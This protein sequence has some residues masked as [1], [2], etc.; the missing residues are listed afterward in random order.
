MQKKFT[1]IELLVVIA[2]IAILAGM[3]LPA[4]NKARAKARATACVNNLKQNGLAFY[5]Y[6]D[7]YN[8]FLPGPGGVTKNTYGSWAHTMATAGIIGSTYADYAKA[9]CPVGRWNETISGY[10]TWQLH[11]C[12][13][14]S[15]N[16]SLTNAG[17]SLWKAPTL[18][19]IGSKSGSN[20]NPGG[21][22]QTVLLFDGWSGSRQHYAGE[23]SDTFPSVRHN[24]RANALM[25]DGSVTNMTGREAIGTYKTIKYY[26]ADMGSPLTN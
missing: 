1:L 22:N 17:A 15:M 16:S 21:I 10:E 23:F 6:A 19:K 13:V 14:Y 3:L 8:D 25:G 12:Q 2:I 7:T 4:L 24:D 9:R 11:A 26:V 18:A 20:W 5:M